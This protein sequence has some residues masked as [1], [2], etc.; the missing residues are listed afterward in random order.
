MSTCL[1]IYLLYITCYIYI[2]ICA[3]IW[4]WWRQGPQSMLVT[5]WRYLSGLSAQH[6]KATHKD[7]S[8][9]RSRSYRVLFQMWPLAPKAEILKLKVISLACWSHEKHRI[10]RREAL[11]RRLFSCQCSMV[12]ALTSAT[13]RPCSFVFSTRT[14][15]AGCAVFMHRP[16]WRRCR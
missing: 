10:K 12:M 16:R 8:I 5:P 4:S 6:S 1:F 3:C 9:S 7:R 11:T 15:C 14:G 2:Y 13:W